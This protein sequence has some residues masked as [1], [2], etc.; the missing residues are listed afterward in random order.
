MNRFLLI[1]IAMLYLQ[2]SQAETCTFESGKKIKV[3]F[4]NSD[5]IVN[6]KYSHDYNGIDPF[7]WR[8]FSNE[9]YTYKLSKP[10]KDGFSIWMQKGKNVNE[11]G[12]CIN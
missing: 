4:N 12:W 10:S 3:E 2:Y 8:V 5:L 1:G 11:Q 9:A 6:N 7:G